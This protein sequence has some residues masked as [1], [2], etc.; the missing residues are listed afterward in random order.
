MRRPTRA[1]LE[2]KATELGIVFAANIERQEAGRS[3]SLRSWL[4]PPAA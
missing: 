1:E 4:E 2:Q 3:A